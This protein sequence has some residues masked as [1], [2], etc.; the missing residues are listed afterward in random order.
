[1][2]STA[3]KGM[4]MERLDSTAL[5]DSNYTILPPSSPLELSDEHLMLVLGGNTSMVTGPIDVVIGVVASIIYNVAKDILTGGGGDGGSGGGGGGGSGG[6][7]AG[8]GGS[9]G[10]GGRG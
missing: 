3:L 9:G 8:G 4:T 6:G 7:G 1:M 5:N 2:T 10:A